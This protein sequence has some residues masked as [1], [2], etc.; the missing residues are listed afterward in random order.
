MASVLI[1]LS[2]SFPVLAQTQQTVGYYPA[3]ELRNIPG[4]IYDPPAEAYSPTFNSIPGATAPGN[5]IS[6][7]PGESRAWKT[8]APITDVVKF[9]DLDPKVNPQFAGFT[10]YTL[11]DFNQNVGADIGGVPLKDVQLVNGLNLQQLK[12]IYNNGN[13]K[14]KD[15]LPVVQALV[16]VVFDPQ[17]AQKQLQKNALSTAKKALLNRLR[18]EKSLKDVPLEKILDGDW[19]GTIT[20]GEALLLKEL[21]DDLPEHIQRL[22]IGSL[23][24]SVIEG[25]FAAVRQQ[26]Q[27]YAVNEIYD[28]TLDE[29]LQRFPDLQKVPVGSIASIANQPL[30]QSLPQ[31]ADLAIE[32][33]PGVEDKFLSAVPG[34]G[35]SPVGALLGDVITAFIAGDVFAKFDILHSGQQGPEEFLGRPLSGGTPDNKFKVIPGIKSTDS[36]SKDPKKGFPRW[37]MRPAVPGGLLGGEPI[38][39]KEWMGRTQKVPGCKGIL[40][41]F[42]K[43]ESAGIKPVKS[44]PVKFSLGELEENANGPSTSRVWVDFQKCIVVFFTK[45]CTAHIISFKTPWKVKNGSLFPVLARRRIQDYFPGVDT[46]SRTVDFCQVPTF[47]TSDSPQTANAGSSPP[48]GEKEAFDQFKQAS[49]AIGIEID[50]DPQGRLLIDQNNELATISWVKQEAGTYGF[51]VQEEGNSITFNYTGITHPS[52]A[53]SQTLSND[54]FSSASKPGETLA[55]TLSGIPGRPDLGPVASAQVPSQTSNQASTQG[56][57]AQTVGQSAWG[58]SKDIHNLILTSALEST[59]TQNQVDVAVAIMNRVVSPKHPNTIT[60]VVYQPKQYQPN[61]GFSPVNTKEEAIAR[62]ALKTG[63]IQSA[64][65]EYETLEAALND[66]NQ[67][68]ASQI[69]LGGA[70]DFRGQKLLHNSKPGDPYRGNVGANWYLQESRDAS[71]AAT[72]LG[73]L[74][75]ET[76]AAD[77]AAIEAAAV[78]TVANRAAYCSQIGALASSQG[79]PTGII[80]PEGNGIATGDFGNP[81]P[82]YP[83]TSRFG[84]RSLGWHGGIDLGTPVG[85][86]VNASD[87]G[88]VE[89]IG[90]QAGGYGN[91]VIINHKNGYSTL[92]AHLSEAQVRVN[93]KVTKNTPIALSGNTGR[94]TGPHLHFEIIRTVNGVTPRKGSTIN[95]EFLVNF[96]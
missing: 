10:K 81:N 7:N 67:I 22:P 84:H 18:K 21:K 72:T 83:V 49:S 78:Q 39:G 17:G 13:I 20:E 48:K 50:R 19:R 27:D 68:K 16:G 95:P 45:H 8:G 86:P 42:G 9:R 93:Q 3:H 38:L 43:W 92:Y 87:G 76:T 34:L 5:I 26:A 73:V 69:F 77:I 4:L 65:S 63:S 44:A 36:K 6:P 24:I 75:I 1:A 15:S 94:S 79:V 12:T 59:G 14:I 23:T 96:N 62:I 90:Y 35:D 51:Q 32:N 37:E 31:I 61:F 64:I 66:P 70:T 56:K 60:D 28:L 57:Q 80:Q 30:D 71:V 55:P 53:A 11:R 88:I 58:S 91:Y 85:T 52:P 47:L 2:Q 29:A 74:G 89:E 40:C 54:G 41:I 46:T 82:G 33:I 25:D